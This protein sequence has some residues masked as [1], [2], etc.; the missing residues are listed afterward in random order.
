MQLSEIKPEGS[1]KVLRVAIGEEVGK[2]LVDMG[3]TEGTEGMVV[4]AGLLRGP[5]QVKLRGFDLILRR[6]EAAGIEIE[7]LVMDASR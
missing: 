3:F 5:M 6:D 1:F 4:R 2:R 7:A